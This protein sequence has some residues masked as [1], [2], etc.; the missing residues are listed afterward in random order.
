MRLTE[1]IRLHPE[2]LAGVGERARQDAAETGTS[3]TYCDPA[4]GH[5]LLREWPRTGRI[6]SIAV[7]P[8]GAVRVLE[9]LATGSEGTG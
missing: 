4:V 8:G 7:L 1:W 3:L 9:V 2:A 6:E 5:G